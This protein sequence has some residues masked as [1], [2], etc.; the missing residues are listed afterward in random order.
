MYVLWFKDLKIA[1]FCKCDGWLI[2]GNRQFTDVFL[3]P[4][5]DD[6]QF[7]AGKRRFRCKGHHAVLETVVRDQFIQPAGRGQQGA[8]LV[9][10]EPE[11]VIPEIGAVAF[12]GRTADG[13]G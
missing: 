7:Y 13:E 6:G 11:G 2:Y 5:I 1:I 9:Q 8:G 10:L 12:T 4:G 3:I